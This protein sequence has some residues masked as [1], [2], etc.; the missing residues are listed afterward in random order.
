MVQETRRSV[1]EVASELAVIETG[2][3]VTADPVALI[4][5]RVSRQD[6]CVDPDPA[7]LLQF[8]GDFVGIPDDGRPRAGAGPADARP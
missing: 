1:A 4:E 5:M 3:Y 6:E 2:Q 8:V 7:V